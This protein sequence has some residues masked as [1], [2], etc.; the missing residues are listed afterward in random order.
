MQ[1][2]EARIQEISRNEFKQSFSVTIAFFFYFKYQGMI[3]KYIEKLG[4]LVARFCIFTETLHTK[5]PNTR[6]QN[7]ASHTQLRMHTLRKAHPVTETNKNSHTSV[8]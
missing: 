8:T 2:T 7:P 4:F 6:E 1:V 3:K 5:T